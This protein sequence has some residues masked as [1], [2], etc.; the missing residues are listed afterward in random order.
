[1]ENS[2]I[3]TQQFFSDLLKQSVVSEILLKISSQDFPKEAVNVNFHIKSGK[4]SC[5]NNW[6]T[7]FQFDSNDLESC[8][9]VIK[10]L[11]ETDNPQE[12]DIIFFEKWRTDLSVM[13][14]SALNDTF[15]T[16]VRKLIF[17]E[18]NDTLFPIRTIEVVDIDITSRPDNDKV[19]V[20][21]KD[22]PQGIQTQPVTENLIKEYERTQKDVNEIIAEKKKNNDQDYMWITSA[23]W[24][25]HFYDIT[26]SL[27]VDYSQY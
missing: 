7:Q 17:G 10:Y 18:D 11:G 1:M 3:V 9:R 14:S 5:S 19:L 12:D 27:M 16:N 23:T 21:R 20:V 22:T 6:N 8:S 2:N 25:K 26:V 24:T 13:L 4:M 15:K